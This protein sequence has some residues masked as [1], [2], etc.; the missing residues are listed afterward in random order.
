MK[1]SEEEIEERGKRDGRGKRFSVSQEVKRN[2]NGKKR[3]EN[4]RIIFWNVVEIENKD[5]DF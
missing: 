4:K 3:N 2:I 1:E 5:L